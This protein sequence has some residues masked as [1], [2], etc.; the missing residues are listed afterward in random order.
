MDEVVVSG[1]VGKFCFFEEVNVGIGYAFFQA[2]LY[3]LK[4]FFS[5][6]KFVVFY[7]VADECCQAAL[8]EPAAPYF[9]LLQE[10]EH[11]LFVVAAEVGGVEPG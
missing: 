4:V 1:G 6:W 8:A 2:V 11:G 7:F 10:V 5:G 3:L 9:R